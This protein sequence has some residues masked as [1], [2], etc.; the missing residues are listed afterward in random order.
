MIKN[1]WLF[2]IT[3]NVILLFNMLDINV[4]IYQVSLLMFMT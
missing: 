3:P 1:I 4:I 2:D